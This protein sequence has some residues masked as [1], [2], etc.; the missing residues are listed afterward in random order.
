MSTNLEIES[1]VM[2]NKE[3]Y[4]K[5][6]S[7]FSDALAYKQTNYYI[8][9]DE[10]ISKYKNYGMRI[11]RKNKKYELTLKV[12]E[13]I[14]KTEINQSLALKEVIKFRLHNIFPE[15]EVK[16]YLISN[17]VCEIKELKVLGKMVTY[18]TDIPFLTSLISIDK[19]K[20]NGITD[21]EIECEDKTEFAAKNNLTVF[22]TQHN[23]KYKKTEAN[24]LGR[25]L[26]TLK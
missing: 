22:V 5:L 20:Y 15:G 2:I 12:R 25:F 4:D 17:K 21:Y 1:K 14:G 8:G 23:I 16:D 18:R 7:L 24:K 13:M 26:S 19:S 3:A 11:R 6:E 9:S 10:L